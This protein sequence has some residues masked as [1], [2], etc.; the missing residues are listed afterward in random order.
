MSNLYNLLKTIIEKLNAT[1]KSVNGKTGDITLNASD[2]GADASGTAE[3]KVSTH[4]TSIDSHSD[5]RLL[6][7]GLTNRLNTLA[8]SD[9]VTLDQLSEVVAYIKSNRDLI[10]SITTSKVNVEDIIDNLTTNVANKP[11]SAAQGVALKELIDAI[12]I[13]EVDETLSESGKAADAAA[14]GDQLSAL[15]EEIANLP[16]SDWNQNDE[17]AHDYVKNRPFYTSA[18]V[19]TVLV[20][21]STVTFADTG[22]GFYA[23]EFPSTFEGTVGE[24][25]KVY[26]DGA[27]YECTCV[28]FNNGQAIGNL[29]V[30]GAG[31]DTSEPFLIGI[32]NDGRIEIATQNTSSSHTFSISAKVAQVVKIDKKYLVQPDWNQNDETAAD[33]VKNRPFYTGDPAKTVLVEESTVSFVTGDGG[34]M[35]ATLPESFDLVDGQTY[36]VSWDGTDYVCTGILLRGIPILGNLEIAGIGDNTGEP[37]VFL[38]QG[39]WAVASTES[40]TEHV[41]AI[42]EYTAQIVK[43]DKK[44]LPDTAFTEAEWDFIS[45][46]PLSYKQLDVNITSE[47]TTHDINVGNNYVDLGVTIPDFNDGLYYKVEGEISFRNNSAGLAY[48]LQINGYYKANSSAMLSLG[49]VYDSY[50]RRSLVV[51]L[52]GN[53]ARFYAGQLGVFTS[54]NSLSYTITADFTVI[55]EVKKLSE[56][57]MPD[58]TAKTSDI[59]TDDHINELINTAL[60]SIGVAEEGAY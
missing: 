28:K 25:Y 7:S 50:S 41:I 17:T 18:P 37:F 12:S 38:N 51:S 34:V 52:H 39:Q 45:N 9:D 11:L 59:P 5:I 35:M 36:S 14:V 2:V 42:S 20:E 56:D 19:E 27:A 46:R 6:I 1:V 57:Y 10:S 13:P 49:T 4:N 23:A 53:N 44:Y 15:S 60:N 22:Y 40:A 31:S 33:Y 54:G 24:T 3:S 47:G 48:P 58:S 29:S 32:V 8:D 43:I 21:E 30:A 16:Q 26:W 55:S